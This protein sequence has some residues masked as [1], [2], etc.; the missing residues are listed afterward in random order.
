[1]DTATNRSQNLN[2]LL[3][4]NGI[5]NT[6]QVSVLTKRAVKVIAL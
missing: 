6:D 5:F 1:M 4:K 2:Y 3:L